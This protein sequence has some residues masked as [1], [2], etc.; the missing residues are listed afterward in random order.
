MAY[1]LKNDSILSIQKLLLKE[2]KIRVP[3][4]KLLNKV[5]RGKPTRLKNPD[6]IM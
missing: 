6:N 2:E 3:T 1:Q 4:H 5:L